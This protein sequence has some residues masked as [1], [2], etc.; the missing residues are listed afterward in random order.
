MEKIKDFFSTNDQFAKHAGLELL[1]AEKGYAR[2]KMTIQ[3][4]HLNGV[5][6]VHGGALFTLADFALAVAS[7]SHGRIAM[8][9]NGNISYVKAVSDG[10]LYAEAREV[11]LNHK[12]GNYLVNIYDEQHELIAVFQ[13]MV[14]RKQAQ[15][16]NQGNKF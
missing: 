3:K 4:F 9:I 2:V 5:K 6:T 15:I 14:Y 13:G 11:S 8:G 7:N 16:N 1:V 12:L 10:T